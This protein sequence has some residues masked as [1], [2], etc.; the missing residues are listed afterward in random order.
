M[1]TRLTSSIQSVRPI[2]MR[3]SPLL[4]VVMRTEAR[5]ASPELKTM[6][7]GRQTR[8]RRFFCC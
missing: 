2:V 1:G 4:G 6:F 7:K 8:V 5:S 3:H